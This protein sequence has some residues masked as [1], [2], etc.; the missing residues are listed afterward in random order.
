MSDKK[1]ALQ[2]VPHQAKAALEKAFN[3]AIKSQDSLAVANIAR[4]RR[5]HPEKTPK[6]LI[7]YLNK[8]YLG[9]VTASGAGAGATAA[10]PNIAIQLPA[11]ILELTAF[12]EVS[13]FYVL[14]IAEIN[15]L[16]TDDLE[17]RKLLVASAFVGESITKGFIEKGVGPV[18]QHLGKLIVSN[19]P[20]ESIKAINKVLGPRFIT[21]TGTKTGTLVLSKQA[22]LFVGA[23]LGATGNHLFA[24][25]TVR[26]TRKIVGPIPE[27]WD[28]L[29]IPED[30]TEASPK[31]IGK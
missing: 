12:L 31:R 24:R 27:D 19:I 20:R 30:K 23:V 16:H 21:I 5:V 9:V 2:K 14:S 26:A 13:V 22:P 17:R 7:Q 4:L 29:R 8:W 18:S 1:S 15:G 3:S 25:L 6:E 28:H 11:A 10:V